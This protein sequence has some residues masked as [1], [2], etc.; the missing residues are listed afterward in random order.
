MDPIL[1]IISVLH[2]GVIQ[3]LQNWTEFNIYQNQMY[4]SEYALIENPS[5]YNPL[6][7]HKIM[8]KCILLYCNF[9]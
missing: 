3:I 4:S 6:Q 9:T 5:H 2:I 1:P 7:I 8:L